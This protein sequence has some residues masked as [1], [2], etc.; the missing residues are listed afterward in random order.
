ML[1]PILV[2]VTFADVG[3]IIKENV[4]GNDNYIIQTKDDWFIAVEWY[5]GMYLNEGDVVFGTLKTYGFQKIIK[6][7]GEEV[8]IYI[9]DYESTIGKAFEELCE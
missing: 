7:D 3:I 9:E 1:L 5:G 2:F 6:E 8:Q 4:C